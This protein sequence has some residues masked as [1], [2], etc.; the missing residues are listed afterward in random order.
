MC[1]RHK[2]A[3]TPARALG[4]PR[5]DDRTLTNRITVKLEVHADAD[6]HERACPSGFRIVTFA[7]DVA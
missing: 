6:Q 1:I 5:H 7:F 4:L 3:R 2:H